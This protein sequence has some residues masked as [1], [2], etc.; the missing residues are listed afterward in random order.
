MK[1]RLLTALFAVAVGT[2]IAF[3]CAAPPPSS[4]AGDDAGTTTPP[5]VTDGGQTGSGDVDAG[6][7]IEDAGTTADADAGLPDAG[8]SEPVVRF[9]AIGDSGKGN[10]GQKDVA[11]AMVTKCAQSGCDLVLMLGDNIY[12]TGVSGTDDPQWQSKFEVPYQNVNLPFYVS[13]GNHD[14]GGGGAG[15]EFSKGEH[16]VAYTA[17]STKW[18]LPD[19]YYRF[20]EKHVEFFA[21]DSNMQMYGLDGTQQTDLKQWLADSTAVW[22]IVFGHHPYLSNGPHGNAGN[23]DG[24]KFVPI[25]NGKGVK[26]F[27]DDVWCGNADFYL[28]GHDH[29]RQWLTDTCQGTQ[30]IVSGA[31]AAVTELDGSNPTYFQQNTLGFVWVEIKG[32]ALTAEFI[33]VNGTV[34]FTRTVTK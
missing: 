25:A 11:A 20:V 19:E 22:K 24:L 8:E 26:D 1:R 2:A 23:Y 30:L 21:V 13:L 17:L 28:S 15:N 32:R 10:Q 18:K 29:S 27:A 12:D 31:A 16:Q 5:I 34:E 4:V 7:G 33:D 6:T 9:I 3:S 14:Y